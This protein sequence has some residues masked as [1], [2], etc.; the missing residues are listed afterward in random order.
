MKDQDL[1]KNNPATPYKLKKAREKGQVAKS[2]SVTSSVVLTIMVLYVLWYGLDDVYKH[3]MLD[4]RL[5]AH[6]SGQ[7]TWDVAHI[8]PVVA[9]MI[10]QILLLMLPFF[11]VLIIASVIANCIQ[12]G[13]LFA[14]EFIKPQFDRINPISGFKRIFSMRS[15]FE[16]FIA[17]LK[18]VVL[19]SVAAYSLYDLF[20]SV[21]HVPQRSTGAYLRFLIESVVTLGVRL[22][23]VLLIIAL[24]D[25]L[26]RRYDFFKKM[27]M[28]TKELRDEFK[29]RDGDPR[30]KSKRKELR[31]EFLQKILAMQQ[32]GA[33]DVVLT[34]PTHYA[35]ALKYV[36]GQMHAPIVVCKGQGAMASRI[37]DVA[38]KHNIP[39]FRSPKLTRE[40]YGSVAIHAPIPEHLY[41]E[42]A[43]VFHWLFLS[44]GQ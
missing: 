41:K 5:F 28:S 29:N 44:Q 18:L 31:K 9:M 4:H 1:D 16:A 22:A 21:M 40:I 20:S 36:H 13:F 15:L 26:Y 37:R 23:C 25:Y 11:F 24:L 42:V 17:F 43:H 38:S 7:A 33:A 12:F 27:R 34:N 30:L 19:M 14:P 3:Y 39:I 10:K 32:A 6:L 8:W 35:V 2:P